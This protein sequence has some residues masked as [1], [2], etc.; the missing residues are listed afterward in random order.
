[1]ASK[2]SQAF[3]TSSVAL[4]ASGSVALELAVAGLPAVI[5]YKMHPISAMVVRLMVTARFA[6]LVNEIMGRQVQPEFIQE[7]AKP[8]PIA[9]ALARLL[10]SEEARRDQ[11]VGLTAAAARLAPGDQAPSRIAARSVLRVIDAGNP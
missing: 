5:T 8:V 10:E 9:R 6:S 3:A 11:L 1:M 4:A 7:R 2:K